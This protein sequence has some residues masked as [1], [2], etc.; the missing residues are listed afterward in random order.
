MGPSNTFL[1]NMWASA[2]APAVRAPQQER[3]VMVACDMEA[4]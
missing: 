4:G 2:Q 3:W 1:D